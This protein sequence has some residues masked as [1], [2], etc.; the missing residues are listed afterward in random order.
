MFKSFQST[1]LVIALVI[2]GSFLINDII[3][4]NE[5]E[6]AI[7]TR[8]GK[9]QSANSGGW[10]I[11]TPIIDSVAA[12]YPIDIQTIN[13]VASS[14]SKDQQTLSINVNTQYRLDSTKSLEMFKAFR[15]EE[16]LE[17]ETLPPIVQEVTKT[18]ASR[19]T[20]SELLSGRDSIKLEVEKLL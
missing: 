2:V 9:V 14:A 20:S 10:F 15:S 4:I 16:Q 11:K 19:Y 17:K 7:I 3:K 8:F 13:V 1:I 12:I 5:R 18:V 6:V